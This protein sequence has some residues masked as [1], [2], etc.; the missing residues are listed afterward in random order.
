[1]STRYRLVGFRDGAH[2]FFEYVA[3]VFLRVLELGAG[4]D[5]ACVGEGWHP[6]AVY[7]TGVPATMIDVQ[8]T[9]QNIV[10]ILPLHSQCLHLGLVHITGLLVPR[11]V[12]QSFDLSLPTHV[13]MSTSERRVRTR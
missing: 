12:Y 10:D 4:E 2:A 13:S 9:A 5:V 6:S 7:Q 1:M 8:M 11:L 3:A